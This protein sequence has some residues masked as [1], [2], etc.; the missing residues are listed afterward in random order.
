MKIELKC[1]VCGGSLSHTLEAD[2]YGDAKMSVRPCSACVDRLDDLFDDV[3]IACLHEV[4]PDN[5]DYIDS[6]V[7]DLKNHARKG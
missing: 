4:V 3:R 5:I 7:G 1:S 2:L 6:F